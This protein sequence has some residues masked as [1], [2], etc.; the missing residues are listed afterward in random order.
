MRGNDVGCS[1][2]R[3]FVDGIYRRV[4]HDPRIVV[5]VT[6]LW[7]GFAL[8]GLCSVSLLMIGVAMIAEAWLHKKEIDIW[9]ETKDNDIEV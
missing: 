8:I 9:E 7:V 1:K 5:E 4:V 3:A 2:Y 6:M